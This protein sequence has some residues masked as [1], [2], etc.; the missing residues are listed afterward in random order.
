MVYQC[1]ICMSTRS[2]MTSPDKGLYAHW[3][4]HTHTLWYAVM[5]PHLFARRNQLTNHSSG[6]LG[7][8]I[9]LMRKWPQWSLMSSTSLSMSCLTFH[10]IQLHLVSICFSTVSPLLSFWAHFHIYPWIIYRYR[11]SMC[12]IISYMHKKCGLDCKVPEFCL[13]EWTQKS[14]RKRV[15]ALDSSLKV[16]PP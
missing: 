15:E 1:I 9:E 14:E 5:Y 8:V 2:V 7:D 6:W 3:H 10:L 4:T 13:Q 16:T 11:F 12:D